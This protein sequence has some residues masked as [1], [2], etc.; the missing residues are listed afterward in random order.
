MGNNLNCK[1][2]CKD[3]INDEKMVN[4][5]TNSNEINNIKNNIYNNNNIIISIE[6]HSIIKNSNTF[7]KSKN[8]ILKENFYKKQDNKNLDVIYEDN[9]NNNNNNSNNSNIINQSEN[10]IT[11][12]I[13]EEKKNKC[14]KGILKNNNAI[15]S[16][17][18]VF[19]GNIVNKNNLFV[20]TKIKKKITFEIPSK[21]IEKYISSS[22]NTKENIDENLKNFLNNNKINILNMNKNYN[23]DID[24]LINNTY[25]NDNIFSS[26]LMDVEFIDNNLKYDLIYCELNTKNQLKFFKNKKNYSLQ[27]AYLI[28]DLNSIKKV[29]LIEFLNQEIIKKKEKKYYYFLI[30]NYNNFYIFSNENEEIINK[31]VFILNYFINY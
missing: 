6:D 8:D 20:K 19:R 14:K 24:K 17:N 15:K 26:N 4:F 22:F 2:N 29:Y 7:N 31:W 25:Y 21:P 3:K 23:F 18:S 10:E 11:N 13:K 27:N 9:N 30:Y 1:C 5:P 28:L 12:E 16:S